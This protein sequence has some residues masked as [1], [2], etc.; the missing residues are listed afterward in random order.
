MVVMTVLLKVL[1]DAMLCAFCREA[2]CGLWLSALRTQ[3]KSLTLM[4][5]ARISAVDSHAFCVLK[6]SVGLTH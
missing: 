1:H 3:G 5:G 6:L 4:L 2:T